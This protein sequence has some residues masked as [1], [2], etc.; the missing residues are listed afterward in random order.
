MRNFAA[1]R[2][3]DDNDERG[4][5]P[6]CRR[7]NDEL[8]GT[9]DDD[10]EPP[11]KRLRVKARLVDDTT[12]TTRSSK[13]SKNEPRALHEKRFVKPAAFPSLDTKATTHLTD[14]IERSCLLKQ[15][16]DDRASGDQG[17]IKASKAAMEKV[18]ACEVVP[19]TL[20]MR[21]RGWYASVEAN[22][23]HIAVEPGVGIFLHSHE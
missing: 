20:L 5:P 23:K 12:E 11:H 18:W 1:R 7:F 14:T 8:D 13:E 22:L 17:R 4:S 3:S 6:P 10:F 9:F 15:M 21:E 16:V 19:K 2:N